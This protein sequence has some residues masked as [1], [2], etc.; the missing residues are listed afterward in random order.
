MPSYYWVTKYTIHSDYTIYNTIS[1][2]IKQYDW[3]FLTVVNGS[4]GCQLAPCG[5]NAKCETKDELVV[6]SCPD[7]YKGDPL[8][9]C[10][11]KCTLFSW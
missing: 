6:C 5:N 8:E 9:S 4:D 10:E 2:R 7:G 3:T 11:R 1:N